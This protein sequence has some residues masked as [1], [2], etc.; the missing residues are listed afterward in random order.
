[1]TTITSSDLWLARTWRN[2]G[3]M[4]LHSMVGKD[5]SLLDKPLPT[6]NS[7]N[8]LRRFLLVFNKSEIL[9][10]FIGQKELH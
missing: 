2:P 6:W 10:G 7:I 9:N 5:L 3:K 4:P 1:M 8:D